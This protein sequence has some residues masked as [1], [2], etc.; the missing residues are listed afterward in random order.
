MKK[1]ISILLLLCLF[2]VSCSEVAEES[3]GSESSAGAVSSGEQ[4]ATVSEE[5]SE[6]PSADTSS[7]AVED[8]SADTSSDQPQ[9]DPADL[10]VSGFAE[11]QADEFYTWNPVTEGDLLIIFRGEDANV[12]CT[13]EECRE[14]LCSL[15][16][17]AGIDPDLVKASFETAVEGDAFLE[18]KSLTS[19]YFYVEYD[20]SEDG[21]QTVVY[22]VIRV[23]PDQREA[24]EIAAK[25]YDKFSVHNCLVEIAIQHPGDLWPF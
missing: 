4:S 24:V 10:F 20:V 9:E 12:M 17:I 16:E 22:A 8:S 3:K 18:E 23:S 14:I 2:L 15:Y 5:S 21:A 19:A 25:A 1:Y 13:R 7:E 11:R 6:N